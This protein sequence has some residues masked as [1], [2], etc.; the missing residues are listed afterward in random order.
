[1]S[2]KSEQNAYLTLEAALV[3]PI[4]TGVILLLL[5]LAFFQYDR[6]LLEQDVGS[7]ALKGGTSVQKDK[8]ALREELEQAAAGL[9]REKYVAWEMTELSVEL[10]GNRVSV[11]GGGSIAFPFTYL[12]AER[13][14]ASWD[15]E[16][17]YENVRTD[18]A[19][20]IRLYHKITGG[21]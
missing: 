15:A 18:P 20:F 7:L 12:L 13:V 14:D 11:Q 21:E 17:Q 6:C 16:V 4:V 10:S 1:M 2:E 5:Y 8:K 3:L 9:Y 19:D